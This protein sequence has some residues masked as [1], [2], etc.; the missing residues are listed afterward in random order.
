[1]ETSDDP[2]NILLLGAFSKGGGL[3]QGK[4]SELLFGGS[5]A[6]AARRRATPTVPKVTAVPEEQITETARKK[7]RRT[8]S[9]LTAQFTPPKLGL[10]GLLGVGT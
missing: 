8:A 10:K 9:L 5:L 4:G 1:M 6:G 3:L 2:M 7:R